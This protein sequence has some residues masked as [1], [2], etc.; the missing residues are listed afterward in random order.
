[1][2]L[3]PYLP[4][5]QDRGPA[6]SLPSLLRVAGM[7]SF[8]YGGSPLLNS[9]ERAA[10]ERAAMRYEVARIIESYTLTMIDPDAETYINACADDVLHAVLG[11]QV[12]YLTGAP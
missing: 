5:L 8:F 6:P 3:P 2:D 4:P 9:Q 11:W 12:T 10:A 7:S 1:M